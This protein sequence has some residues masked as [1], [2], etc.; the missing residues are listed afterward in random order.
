[1]KLKRL[2]A[3]LMALV[4]MLGMLPNAAMAASSNKF[5]DVK[6]TYWANEYI[7]ALA[8]NGIITG[9]TNGNF[10]PESGITREEFAVVLFKTFGLDEVKP[11]TSSF[12]DVE[13]TRWSYGY[14]EAAKTYLTGYF[15]PNGKP[16][17]DPEGAATREDV[18]VALVRALNLDK[19]GTVTAEDDLDF[20]DSADVSPNL[21]NEVALA[22]EHQLISGFPDG[23]FLPTAPVTRAQA[24]AMVYKIIKNTYAKSNVSYS[25]EIK[26]PDTV[27]SNLVPISI[28]L[29]ANSTLVIND[30]TVSYNGTN[31]SGNWKLS[32]TGTQLFNIHVTYPN[33]KTESFAKSVVYTASAPVIN[34]LDSVPEKVTNSKL[35]FRFAVTDASGASL[36]YVKVNGSSISKNYFSENYT[37]NLNLKE[38]INDIVI[39]VKNAA[40][41]IT[42]KT[43]RVTYETAATVINVINL[44]SETNKSEISFD[45]KVTDAYDNYLYLY[46]NNQKYTVTSDKIKTIN[47]TLNKGENVLTFKVI[48]SQNKTTIVTK[49][50]NYQISTP[51]ISLNSAAE[52]IKADYTLSVK[53]S[54]PYYKTPFLLVKINGKSVTATSEGVV[55]FPVTLLT[56]K[57]LFTVEVTNP[58]SKMVKSEISIQY[59]PKAPVITADLPS[60]TNLEKPVYTVKVQDPS[61]K[62]LTA[63]LGSAS[64]PVVSK[65]DGQYEI[66]IS[67]VLVAGK[68]VI[69][70]LVTSDTGLTTSYQKEITFEALAPV[71][72][73][74]EIPATVA[75]AKLVING[76]V[77]DVNDGSVILKIN[78]ETVTITEAGTFSKEL[79]LVAGSN[80]ITITAVNKLGLETKINKTVTYTPAP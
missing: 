58:D 54:D 39:E 17:F 31:Y 1:M 5:K 44:P 80:T 22:V 67:P 48:N 24:S 37:A 16:T 33:G 20:R 9:Y 35:S 70:L 23:T 6:T 34:L 40:G 10:A 19:N 36:S 75:A 53:V 78:G 71:V 59:S 55:N 26:I 51:V 27:S 69:N 11:T 7:Q 38:G 30:K 4:M 32:S 50:I 41:M 79:T 29:P 43:I 76:N 52:V 47:Y 64:I 15:P 66:K 56:G 72:N 68:N 14:V 18:A 12:K 60:S 46:V 62:S 8:N 45:V 25:T 13:P 57:N 28:K 61:G 42:T 49:T 74:S 63:A 21:R 77:S 73:L 3:L 65:G 2:S